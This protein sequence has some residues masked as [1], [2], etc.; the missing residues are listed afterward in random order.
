MLSFVLLLISHGGEQRLQFEATNPIITQPAEHWLIS[1][2]FPVFHGIIPFSSPD[3]FPKY[4]LPNLTP[5]WA[6]R[7]L[8]A[9]DGIR[10]F[11]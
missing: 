2:D 1:D 7:N 8:G 4:C 5:R 9:S 3:E 6:N 11:E 10:A